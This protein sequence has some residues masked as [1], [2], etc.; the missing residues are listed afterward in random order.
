MVTELFRNVHTIKGNARTYDFSFLNDRVHI[1]E[2]TYSDMREAIPDVWPSAQLLVELHDVEQGLQEYL[3]VYSNELKAGEEEGGES[4]AM[5][6]WVAELMDI[7]RGDDPAAAVVKARE[8]LRE[9]TS[10][11]LDSVLRDLA[12]SARSIAEEL[13]KPMPRIVLNTSGLKVSADRVELIKNVFTHIFR[14]SVDHGL[15]PAAER[16]R[17]G[18][19][20]EGTIVLDAKEQ[21][22]AISITVQDDGRGLNL[23]KLSEKASESGLPSEGLSDVDIANLIFRSGVSTAASVTDISGRGVGMDAVRSFLE[24]DGGAIQIELMGRRNESGYCSFKFNCN[25]PI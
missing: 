5:G 6:P 23:A 18:K 24:A 19:D 2:T 21:D 14:N 7:L 22:G 16:I 8:V 13:D 25:I 12:R 11:T 17:A 3:D 15:E 9:S 1:A 4:V 10:Q 20:P